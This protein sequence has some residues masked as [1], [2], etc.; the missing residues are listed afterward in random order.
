MEGAR[1]NRLT[2]MLRSGVIVAAITLILDQASKFWLLRV[3]DLAERGAVK[4]HVILRPG[5]GLECRDQLRL[6]PE[7]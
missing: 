2:P 5:A 1:S 6:V 7:R 4:I 3:F